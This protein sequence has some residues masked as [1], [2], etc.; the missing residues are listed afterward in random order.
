VSPWLA[1]SEFIVTGV[2][3]VAV[4]LTLLL[5]PEVL[6]LALGGLLIPAFIQGYIC[7]LQGVC[8]TG[9]SRFN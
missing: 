1:L 8:V 9:N 4:Q 5:H 6:G 3:D 7:H 2:I